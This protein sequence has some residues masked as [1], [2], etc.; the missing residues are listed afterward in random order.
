M[1]VTAIRTNALSKSYG[2]HK[3]V[4]SLSLEVPS[5]SV[6]GFLGPNGAGKTTTIRMLLGLSK[7]T[8]GEAFLLGPGICKS[9]PTTRSVPVTGQ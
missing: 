4:N 5:G 1:T 2:E 9:I 6:Y 8:S 7:P 3:A